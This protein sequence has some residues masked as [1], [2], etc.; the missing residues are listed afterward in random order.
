MSH[1]PMLHLLCGKIASGKSTLAQHLAAETGGILISE[2]HWLGTLFADRMTS[3]PDYV[4]CAA[5]LRQVMTPHV[6]GLLRVG[7]SVVLDFPANTPG[8]RVWMRDAAQ[9][10]GVDHRLH[11]L[12]PPDEVCLARLKARNAAGD[13]AFAP[14]EE[15][16]HRISAHFTPPTPD[17]GF[18]VIRYD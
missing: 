5:R 18:T 1:A 9:D 17:E 8:T 10:A 14:T 2:D 6:T 7:V 15:Q 3:V 12:M 13:H 16:F 11:L 4:R